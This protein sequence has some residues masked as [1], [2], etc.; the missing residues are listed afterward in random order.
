MFGGK[1]ANRDIKRRHWEGKRGTVSLGKEGKVIRIF[2]LA[3]GWE[4]TGKARQLEEDY[5]NVWRKQSLYFDLR[6]SRT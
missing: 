5:E 1:G 3:E 2:N 4:K 6:L